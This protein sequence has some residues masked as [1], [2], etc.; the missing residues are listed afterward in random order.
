ML[1]KT[2]WIRSNIHT[3]LHAQPRAKP[4]QLPGKI[5]TNYTHTHIHTYN[6]A[7]T[8]F[9]SFTDA[10]FLWTA[11]HGMETGT[12]IKAQEKYEQVLGSSS[13]SSGAWPTA[14][15]AVPTRS[16]RPTASGRLLLVRSVAETQCLSKCETCML[17]G[18][19]MSRTT[20]K[21]VS[22]PSTSRII[23]NVYLTSRHAWYTV[24]AL[25]FGGV[26]KKVRTVRA[27]IP[28]REALF[29][30]IFLCTRKCLPESSS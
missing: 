19:K 12:R 27:S 17:S 7:N 1:L 22:F 24:R 11:V 14:K 2:N 4:Q 5:N 28:A 6:L 18:F 10:V 13:L 3:S 30:L 29:R 25:F 20:G 9:F 8:L 21:V 26:K 23:S 15:C 16:R